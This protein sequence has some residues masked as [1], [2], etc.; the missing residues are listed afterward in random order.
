M[1]KVF[2]NSLDCMHVYAQQTQET[3][4]ASNVF[5][6]GKRIYSY[7]RHYLLAEF[8][9]V[10][11]EDCILIND[12]GYSVNTSKHIAQIKQAT[13]QYKQFYTSNVDLKQ[14]RSSILNNYGKLLKAKKPEI[15][16]GQIVSKFESLVQYPLI[17][18]NIK[19]SV[20]FKEIEKIYKSVNNPEAIS[21]AKELLKAK[22]LKAA[23]AAAKKLKTDVAKFY[24]YETDYIRNDED[25]IRLSKDGQNIE[26][27]Q[28]VKV[29][30]DEAVL[31]YKMIIANK[32]IKGYKINGYTVI[33]IN[34]TLKVGCHNIN[35]ES[36]HK[37]GK[38]LI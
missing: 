1:K 22:E 32:D 5:F 3:G 38:K 10:N 28:G 7:G 18:V 25:F 11:G 33:S 20:E 2:S 31:L 4:K 14:V 12:N 23:K 19:K 9:T 16:I 29:P 8:I 6:E 26:T 15:Y 13:R 37:T 36:M 21:K 17:T 30:I 27:S 34:G 35:I 24:S